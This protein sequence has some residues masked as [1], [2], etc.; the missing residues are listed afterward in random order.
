M[1]PEALVGAFQQVVNW[2][3]DAMHHD[4]LGCSECCLD[5]VWY[6]SHLVHN[7]DHMLHHCP[8]GVDCCPGYGYQD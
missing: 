4:V 3:Y 1:T 5:W 7:M 6:C 8:L 2:V